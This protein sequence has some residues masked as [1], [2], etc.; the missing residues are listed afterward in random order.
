MKIKFWFYL[1]GFWSCFPDISQS[2]PRMILKLVCIEWFWSKRIETVVKS[3]GN[4]F[5]ELLSSR[6][7]VDPWLFSAAHLLDWTSARRSNPLSVTTRARAGTDN[8]HVYDTYDAALLSGLPLIVFMTA[9]DD[10]SAS[11]AL[12]WGAKL[13]IKGCVNT[14]S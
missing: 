1:V 5:G 10:S 11:P 12:L 9:A 7:H 8:Q 4:L 13:F 2:H 3:H 14:L 6:H